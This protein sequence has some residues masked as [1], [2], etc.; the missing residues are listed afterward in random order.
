MLVL[1]STV[2]HS[3]LPDNTDLAS[4]PIDMLSLS[5]GDSDSLSQVPWIMMCSQLHIETP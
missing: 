3:V 4:L 5:V 1:L 2:T